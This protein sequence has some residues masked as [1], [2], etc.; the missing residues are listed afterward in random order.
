MR[1]ELYFVLLRAGGTD[2]CCFVYMLSWI[3]LYFPTL[4]HYVA[5]YA[6]S[7]TVSC[8]LMPKLVAAFRSFFMK[9]SSRSSE[10]IPS[11]VEQA[12]TPSSL[13]VV[14]IRGEGSLPPRIRQELAG[15]PWAPEPVRFFKKRVVRVFRPFGHSPLAYLYR[16]PSE[17]TS[18][19][20]RFGTDQ[21]TIYHTLD[22]LGSRV[23]PY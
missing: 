1:S 2:H 20:Q 18:V 21:L 11:S 13:V 23:G 3:S 14:P 19:L 12:V 16:I 9:M 4:F 22:P 17:G 15:P 5:P 6:I 8:G 7:H 10:R